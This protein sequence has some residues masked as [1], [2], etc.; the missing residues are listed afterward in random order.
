MIPRS[1][2]SGE[3]EKGDLERVC[4][5][6]YVSEESPEVI[7]KVMVLELQQQSTF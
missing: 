2:S 5:L 1:Y 3:F 4:G 6:I 7:G